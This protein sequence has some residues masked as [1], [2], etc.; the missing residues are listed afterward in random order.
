MAAR[1][2]GLRSN[3]FRCF[4]ARSSLSA[5]HSATLDMAAVAA[6]VKW[7][8]RRYTVRGQQRRC[9]AG[10]ARSLTAAS[11]Y[12]QHEFSGWTQRSERRVHKEIGS[13]DEGMRSAI[14]ITTHACVACAHHHAVSVEEG[15]VKSARP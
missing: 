8:P 13:R 6:G 2:L 14:A 4:A 7:K 11:P 15:Y 12:E 9:C 3:S 1:E 10:N 5:S